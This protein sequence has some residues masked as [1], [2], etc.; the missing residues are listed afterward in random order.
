MDIKVGD[1]VTRISHNHDMV[2]KVVSITDDIANL[3]GMNVRLVADSYISDFIP[4]KA[5]VDPN[6]DYNEFTVNKFLSNVD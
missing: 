1:F 3:K 4:N 2:F 5:T 6:T